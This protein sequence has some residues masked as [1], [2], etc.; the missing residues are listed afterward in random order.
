M[1]IGSTTACCLQLSEECQFQDDDGKKEGFKGDA[2][3]SSAKAAAEAGER[4]KKVVLQ[5][6]T[7]GLYPK[8]YIDKAL[9]GMPGCVW[10]VLKGNHPNGQKLAAIVFRYSTKTTLFC[11]YL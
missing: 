2:W 9:Q 5:V 1:E 10:I 4:G 7:N 3:F 6:K 11:S 8:D